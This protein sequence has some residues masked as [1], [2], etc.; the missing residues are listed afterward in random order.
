MDTNLPYLL[1]TAD[2]A[3]PVGGFAHSFG[4]EGMVQAELIK[5][6]KDL[7]HF[8]HKTW[9]PSVTHIDFPVIRLCAD[10]VDNTKELILLDQ[11]AWASRATVEIRKAQQQMGAQRLQLVARLTKNPL[12]EKMN[13]KVVAGEWMAN[14]PCVWGI[15]AA[16]MKISLHTVM[17]AYAYQ[18]L[19][20]ILAAA[21][22]LIS[23]GPTESQEL[24]MRG[25]KEVPHAIR[26]STD[27]AKEDIGWFTPALDI[28]SAKHETA[29]SRIFIS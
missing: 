3:F 4:L 25:L 29:Y 9:L 15:E 12:L 1:Q 8:I 26:A 19:S 2:S 7:N 28:A 23:I 14:W 6:S 21:L 11:L 16:A 13:D 18:G 10:A 5:T 22:K 17:Q 24:L 20:G 27:I